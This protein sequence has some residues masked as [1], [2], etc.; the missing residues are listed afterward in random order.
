MRQSTSVLAWAVALQVALALALSVGGR[1]NDA[2]Q[3][4]EPMLAFDASQ[5]DGIDIDESAGSSVSLVKDGGKWTIPA[6]LGFPADNGKASAFVAKLAALKRGWPVAT[7]EEAASRFKVVGGSHERRVVLKSGGKKQAELL[8][9]TSPQFRQAYARREGDGS[10]YSIAFSAYEAP[11]RPEDWIDRDVLSV[12]EDKV[13]AITLG[14][15]T[16]TRKDGAF[17]LA[18]LKDRETPKESEIT[19]LVSAALHP[20]FDAV[21]GKGADALAKVA[22]PDVEVTVKMADGKAIV[23]RYKKDAAGSAYL[24][25]RSGSEFLFRAGEAAVEPLVKTAQFNEP[26]E[27]P[28]NDQ[29]SGQA[30]TAPGKETTQRGG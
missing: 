27:A 24:F 28:A 10:V 9:G 1:G 20:Q 25:A 13:A 4:K 30:E 6:F 11:D 14:D 3:A 19:K 12:P 16:L 5:I 2:Y 7:T 29:P 8:I 26:A 15:A 17:A 23:S 21:V 22:T 18:D